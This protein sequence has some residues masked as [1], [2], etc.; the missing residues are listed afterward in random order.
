VEGPNPYAPPRTSLAP[1]AGLSDQRPWQLHGRL[2]FVRKGVKLP[3]ICLYTGAP[4]AAG[5]EARQISWTPPW[6]KV[7]LVLAPLIGI[8]AYAVV[9]RTGNIEYALGPLARRRRRRGLLIAL[10]AVALFVGL[11]LALDAEGWL[12]FW[13]GLVAL[14]VALSVAGAATRGFGVHGMDD[15]YVQLMLTL[16]AAEAFAKLEAAPDAAAG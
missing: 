3:P 12:V 6:F 4:E 7:L 16:P 8:L 15:H 2:L 9:R 10:G 11:L 14:I 5:R 1:G 13:G